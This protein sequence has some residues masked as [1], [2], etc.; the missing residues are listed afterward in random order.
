MQSDNDIVKNVAQIAVC[1]PF[2]NTGKNYLKLFCKF[3]NRL[4][5]RKESWFHVLDDIDSNL[6]LIY[7]LISIREGRSTCDTL[8]LQEVNDLIDF[9][10]IS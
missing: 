9:I 3:N 4:T 6:C 2:S 10:C 5:V 7:E 1:N 8:N